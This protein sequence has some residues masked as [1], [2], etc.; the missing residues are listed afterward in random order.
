MLW[1]FGQYSQYSKEL[2]QAFW[3]F[4]YKNVHLQKFFKMSKKEL[5]PDVVLGP[6]S[7][8]KEMVVQPGKDRT[9]NN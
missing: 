7:D 3:E 2:N 8:T 1:L 5:W 6:D 9:L 4:E